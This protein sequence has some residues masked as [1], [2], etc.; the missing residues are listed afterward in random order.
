MKA[1][2][3]QRLAEMTARLRAAAVRYRAVL[4]VLLAGVLLL[5]SGGRTEQTKPAQTAAAAAT[6]GDG[7]E[8]AAFEQSLEQK[9]A[10][11]DG[12]GRVSLLLS[13]E[14]SE[15]AVYAV[16]TRRSSTG[17]DSQ[18]DE[19]SLAVLSDGGYGETPVTLKRRSPSFRG[20]VVLCDGAESDAV[21]LAVTQAVS[22]ACGMGADK[23]SVLK[24]SP[25]A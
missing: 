22:V 8:L 24:M 10:Q 17:T 2:G 1:F 12:A 11:I 7:F 14:E 19:R 15:E 6:D 4:L 3:S 25:G 5:A 13:L 16:D 9:L 20:A 18:S 23:V 21:R